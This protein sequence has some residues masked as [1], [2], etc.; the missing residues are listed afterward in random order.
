[1]KR[2]SD[3]KAHIVQR[4]GVPE[5]K[6]SIVKIGPRIWIYIVTKQYELGRA[7]LF[8]GALE[9]VEANVVLKRY[10]TTQIENALTKFQY[11]VR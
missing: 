5:K 6:F 3:L 11:I 8:T 4:Y 1:M 10:L 7:L 9:T 2:V